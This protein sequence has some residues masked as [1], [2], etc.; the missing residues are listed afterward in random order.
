MA[1]VCA[2][3]DS[4]VNYRRAVA[5][6]VVLI[7]GHIVLSICDRA[8]ESGWCVG[9][10]THMVERVGDLGQLP[11]GVIS[12]PGDAGGG[13]AVGAGA[14]TESRLRPSGSMRVVGRFA[15]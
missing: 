4:R 1:L 10:R 3:R 6:S 13:G 14:V 7:R 5:V 2:S 11:F 9:Q 8:D 12:E 15:A